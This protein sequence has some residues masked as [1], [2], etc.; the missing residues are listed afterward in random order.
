ME[1]AKMNLL[2]HCSMAREADGLTIY[3]I[4]PKCVQE[5][6]EKKIQVMSIGPGN[7]GPSKSV[8]LLGQTGAGK[9]RVVDAMI[10]HLFGVKFTDN[11]RFQ[12]KD[13]VENNDL[14]QVESQTEYITA[15]IVYYQAGM[16][17]NCNYILID[18]PGF[19][20]TREGYGNVLIQRLTNFLTSNYGIDE[21]N[22]VAL[23]AQATKNRI[24][25]DQI[26]MLDEFT[27]ALGNNIG[28]ITQVLATFA[29]DKSSTVVDVVK[30]VGVKFVN[31]YHL[32]NG[33]LF[34][35]PN[36]DASQTDELI[37]FKHRWKMMQE[38]YAKFF[39]ELQPS[40]PV[41]LKQTRDLLLEHKLLEETKNRL[42]GN[43]TDTAEV[44]KMKKTLTKELKKI[45]DEQDTFIRT[46]TDRKMR[47]KKEYIIAG[48]HAHNCQ[49]CM[50]TCEDYCEDPSNAPAFGMG[51]SYGLVTGM[52]TG[53]ELGV[54]GGPFGAAVGAVAGL[55]TGASVAMLSKRTFKDC[56]LKLGMKDVCGKCHHSKDEHRI[57][58]YRYVPTMPEDLLEYCDKEK[59]HNF[60]IQTQKFE[61]DI[62]KY[63]RDLQD[64]E[65]KMNLE[66][67][68]LVEHTHKINKL[69][70]NDKPLSPESIISDM[71]MEERENTLIV[72]CLQNIR[73]VVTNMSSVCRAV[74]Y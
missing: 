22:C 30:C 61:A 69:S 20:D 34:V 36:V 28:D 31:A 72:E 8:L 39:E 45:S 11:F 10:N 40:T 16:A 5:D 37:Y 23:V 25:K 62:K 46:K 68:A 29:S 57:V 32:D 7:K 60:K 41:N 33:I 51:I 54:F 2:E 55:L 67:K 48:Y 4:K 26:D 9:T 59:C 53:A 50:Q 6:Q 42:R 21:L 17:L 1:T 58:R 73:T 27:S 52:F 18:T 49:E 13:Q 65:Q 24:V 71:I 74:M 56:K 44:K 15:Y 66:A 64:L 70:I 38:E 47:I 63:M 14:L 3:E 12:L 35:S 19:C 43:A